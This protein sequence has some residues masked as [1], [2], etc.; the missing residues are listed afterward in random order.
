MKNITSG[1]LGAM[2]PQ[3]AAS[4]LINA[5]VDVANAR[6]TPAYLTLSITVKD[7]SGATVATSRTCFARKGA[8]LGVGACYPYTK[9]KPRQKDRKSTQHHPPHEPHRQLIAEMQA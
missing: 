4:A 2:G 8:Q 6:P 1:P 5:Q 7:A 3:T 9:I